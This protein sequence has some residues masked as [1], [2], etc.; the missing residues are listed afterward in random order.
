MGKR[1][2]QKEASVIGEKHPTVSDRSPLVRDVVK[3]NEKGEGNLKKKGKSY[4]SV[5][6]GEEFSSK[7]GTVKEKEIELFP[8]DF[9]VI[10]DASIV[11]LGYVKEFDLY[12]NLQQVCETEG[13]HDFKLSYVGG[14][15]F[16]VT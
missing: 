8:V 6:R 15:L 1:F 9:R 10:D 2:N 13:F 12:L 14:K 4:A 16:Y 11:I 5:V 7:E 3:F